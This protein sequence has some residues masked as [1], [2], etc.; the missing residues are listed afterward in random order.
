MEEEKKICTPY[1]TVNGVVP[2]K[3]D[4]HFDNVVCDCNRVVFYSERCGCPA[5]VTPT[6][7]LKSKPNE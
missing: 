3:S 5:N 2:E 4:L 7:E 1:H 6:F